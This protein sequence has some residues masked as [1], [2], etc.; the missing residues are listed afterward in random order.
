MQIIILLEHKMS[1]RLF[2]IKI[3][4]Q[5]NILMILKLNIKEII[6]IKNIKK[7]SI[8]SFR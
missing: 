3:K 5:E 1:F 2:D 6:F 8:T 7:R 4:K